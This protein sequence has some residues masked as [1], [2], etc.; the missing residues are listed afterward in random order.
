MW[1]TSYP[2]GVTSVHM[3]AGEWWTKAILKQLRGEIAAEGITKQ[4]LA[5]RV[6]VAYP[7]LNRY[8]AGERDMPM[9]VL[10]DILAVL[11]IAPE[12]F[13]GR[14]MERLD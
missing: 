11:D 9:P 5:E 13:F 1:L 4:D 14:A 2:F 8:L 3:D 10:F 6:G 12:R 7:S